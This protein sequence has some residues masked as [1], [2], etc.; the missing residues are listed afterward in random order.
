MGNGERSSVRVLRSAVFFRTPQKDDAWHQLG[1]LTPD[2]EENELA[3]NG[4]IEI[5]QRVPEDKSLRYRARW[6]SIDYTEVWVD[7]YYKSTSTGSVTRPTIAVRFRSVRG[8]TGSVVEQQAKH[9]AAEGPSKK[10]RLDIDPG[11]EAQAEAEAE[12]EAR[13]QEAV[14]DLPLFQLANVNSEDVCSEVL[15]VFAKNIS[16]SRVAPK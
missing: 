1:S 2:L 4:G 11:R 12:A 10:R 7:E 15:L 5:W 13:R 9:P 16:I 3:F 8:P 6:E 14:R